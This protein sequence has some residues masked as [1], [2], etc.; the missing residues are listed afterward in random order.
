MS[1]QVRNVHA[2][3]YIVASK[4]ITW[5]QLYRFFTKKEI[6]IKCMTTKRGYLLPSKQALLVEIVKQGEKFTWPWGS[7][8]QTRAV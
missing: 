4:T 1:I 2:T 5:F 8:L 7:M 6:K 3:I